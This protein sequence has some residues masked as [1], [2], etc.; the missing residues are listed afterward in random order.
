MPSKKYTVLCAFKNRHKCP[1]KFKS[2]RD[3]IRHL[4]T[5]TTHKWLMNEKTGKERRTD[6]EV[7]FRRF[8]IKVYKCQGKVKRNN[9]C[10]FS[11]PDKNIWKRHQKIHKK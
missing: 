4:W 6:V 11:T 8:G 3:M 1:D 2:R 9:W 5:S 7:Y 10:E